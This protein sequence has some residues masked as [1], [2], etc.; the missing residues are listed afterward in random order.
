MIVDPS[1]ATG[2]PKIIPAIT[3]AAV[4]A[5]LDGAMV[6][7]HHNP[8]VALSDG[9]QAMTPAEFKAMHQSLGPVAAAVGRKLPK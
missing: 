6:E 1:H 5:G 3:R 7:I 2:L 9:D 8:E 4:A